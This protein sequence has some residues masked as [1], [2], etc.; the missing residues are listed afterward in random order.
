MERT[1]ISTGVHGLDE[2]MQGG[3]YDGSANLITGKTGTGKTSFCA[4][5]YVTGH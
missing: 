4:S 5:F 3:F 1:R 2:K